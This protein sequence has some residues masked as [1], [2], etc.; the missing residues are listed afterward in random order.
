MSKLYVWS[1][2]IKTEIDSRKDSLYTKD[3][4]FF[5]IDRLERMA[6]RIDEF[7]DQCDECMQFKQEIESLSRTFVDSINGSSTDKLV[8][9]KRNE[10]IVNH[11]KKKHGLVHK[12]FYVALYSFLGFLSGS[13]FLGLIFY[14]FKKEYL[15]LGLFMGFAAGMIAGRIYG[16]KKDKF[17]ISRNEIL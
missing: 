4:K 5:K 17:K 11:L 15:T 10:S 14:I 16:R 1:N 8:F 7:S 2:Q 6:Q 13:V 12:D 9:E 3:Y